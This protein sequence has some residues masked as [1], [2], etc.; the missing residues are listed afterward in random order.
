[1]LKSVWNNAFW[2]VEVYTFWKFNQYTWYKI[3]R[4]R[5]CYKKCSLFF[6]RAPAH[7]NFTFDS[8]FLDEL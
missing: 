3:F 7:H 8:W 2:F 5:N 4:Q 6:S 1:M